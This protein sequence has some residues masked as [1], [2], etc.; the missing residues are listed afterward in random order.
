M[1]LPELQQTQTLLDRATTILLLVPEKPS[2]DAFASMVALWLALQTKK[3]GKVD[4][5]SPSHVPK[6][7][8]FLPGSSQVKMRPQVRPDVSIDVAGPQ[9][10]QDMRV[11]KLTGGLRIHI[12]LPEGVSITKDQLETH[13]RAL[14]Y[15]TVVVL[16]AAD[17][18]QLGSLFTAHTDFFYNTPIINIDNRADNEHFGT[19]NL[20]DVTA[21]SIAEVAHEVVVRLTDK[22]EKDIATNLYA[23]IVAGTDQFKKPSTTPKSFKLAAAMLEHGAD[24]EA[25]IQHLVKTKPL[26]LLKLVGRIYA[27]LHY[28]ETPRIFWSVLRSLDFQESG[29]TMDD[30]TDALKELM[31]NIAGFNLTYLI[32]EH[33]GSYSLYVLLGKGLRKR[34]DEIQAM[35]SAERENGLLRSTLSATSLT[36]AERQAQE[37]VRAI[38]P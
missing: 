2:A 31:N 22:I 13:V 30:L 37:K 36:E 28:E 1:S 32:H 14:P 35:L 38:L 17:L 24:R 34:R 5:V 33:E 27:R 21:G 26:Q 25:V 16:G 20:V 11:E 9:S 19:V 6:N 3:E 18:E 8:Q 29:A 15:D 4:E 12:M 23:G 10:V 7:L